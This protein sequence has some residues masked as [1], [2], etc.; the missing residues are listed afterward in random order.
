MVFIWNV[1]KISLKKLFPTMNIQKVRM[2]NIENR[3]CVNVRKRACTGL[4]KQ[5]S[6]LGNS[7]LSNFY[8][9]HLILG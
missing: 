7:I 5:S 3:K 2:F 8:L 1:E 9:R 6:W 4:W